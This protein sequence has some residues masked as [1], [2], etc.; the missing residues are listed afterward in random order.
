M[1]ALEKR[2]TL[3]LNKLIEAARE[4]MEGHE[5]A[6]LIVSKDDK[7]S[8]KAAKKQGPSWWKF[9]YDA[10]R[11]D[12]IVLKFLDERKPS[13]P[14]TY[15]QALELVS[16]EAFLRG[17]VERFC[18]EIDIAI[19]AT[20]PERL[21]P[22]VRA[23]PRLLEEWPWPRPVI[24]HAGSYVPLSASW[25]ILKLLR[26]IVEG[27]DL[28]TADQLLKDMIKWPPALAPL[29]V[30]QWFDTRRE[31]N[32][33][34]TIT[35]Y[36]KHAKSYR[37][38]KGGTPK[39]TFKTASPTTNLAKWVGKHE[40]VPEIYLNPTTEDELEALADKWRTFSDKAEKLKAEGATEIKLGVSKLEEMIDDF[41]R[42]TN[43]HLL[44]PYALALL[45]EANQQA[46]YRVPA[47]PAIAI[48]SVNDQ[49][50]I[51]ARG[52]T[53]VD[54]SRVHDK[55]EWVYG[56]LGEDGP[57]KT[58]TLTDK[59]KQSQLMLP[60][61]D[62]IY[63]LDPEASNFT[64]KVF[65]HVNAEY[66]FDAL[67]ALLCVQT[68]GWMHRANAEQDFWIW[69]D[70]VIEWFG[71]EHTKENRRRVRE[72]I[73]RM[74][75]VELNVTFKSGETHTGPLI[76][77]NQRV[78]GKAG[79]EFAFHVHVHKS[80]F[81]GIQST[82]GRAGKHFGVINRS[83]LQISNNDKGKHGLIFGLGLLQQFRIERFKLLKKGEGARDIVARISVKAAIDRMAIATPPDR[84]INSYQVKCL[85]ASLK[86]C[87]DHGLISKIRYAGELDNPAT[88]L[89]LTAGGITADIMMG[90][91][92]MPRA[93]K[94]PSTLGE[95]NEYMIKGG[96][97]TQQELADVLGISVGSI[98]QMKKTKRHPDELITKGI[99]KAF[100]Q[101][102]WG[103]ELGSKKKKQLE[104]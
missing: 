100:V 10:I 14:I 41:M 91:A 47:P 73:R 6:I 53:G 68:L 55:A 60:M 33:L 39:P 59:K 13:K 104:K 98:K 49:A 32:P 46:E 77:I 71:R 75:Q 56:Q 45:Y 38:K 78:G 99:R 43:V 76:N 15:G 26:S 11:T 64:D 20:T 12:P 4:K 79:E 67:T 93:A 57:I 80:I 23:N 81:S 16:T 28:N 86:A 19:E 62:G 66:G 21:I 7:E 2:I 96:F 87:K 95:L 61:S 74:S 82:D 97:R 29:E 44:P 3:R 30:A 72:I 1:K 8:A 94:I 51:A 42:A 37:K 36:R 102:F 40:Q 58:V 101:T 17:I 22:H 90:V 70:D 50:M 103:L 27:K 92:P 83:M 48:A 84:A 31:E 63:G 65:A 35:A 24:S 88:M 5:S 9:D 69:I 52:V 34:H 18:L 54:V 25:G 89:E 85:E